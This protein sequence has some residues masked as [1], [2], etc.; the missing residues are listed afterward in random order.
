VLKGRAAYDQPA[1]QHKGEFVQ[2][3]LYWKMSRACS[4]AVRPTTSLLCNT[5]ESLRR[6]YA[7]FAVLE[8]EQG[9]L[10]GRA[11]EGQPA[12]QHKGEFVQGLLYWKMSRACSRAVRP[13]TSLLCNTRESLRRVY[14]GFAVL[15][16]EQGVLK[17][18]AAYDQ[19][20][21]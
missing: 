3:L 10:K 7:G 8:D 5:R 21:L 9:V 12:L 13:T 1:L 6:V 20:A 14:A 16:D 11:Q 15:E 4:R 19:P 17:G 2:G 18:R